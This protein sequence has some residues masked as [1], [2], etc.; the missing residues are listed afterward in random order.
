MAAKHY[1]EKIVEPKVRQCCKDL[2]TNVTATKGWHSGVTVWYTVEWGCKTDMF[3]RTLKVKRD[4]N[5][6]EDT[7]M[8]TLGPL[9]DDKDTRIPAWKKGP[10]KP[11]S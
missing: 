7:P 5:V 3:I 1:V 6:N 8:E 9:E 10:G 11:W 4:F 2:D